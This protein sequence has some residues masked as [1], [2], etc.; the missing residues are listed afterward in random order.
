VAFAP[1]VSVANQAVTATDP[2][3]TC[4]CASQGRRGARTTARR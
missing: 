1:D 4:A 2:A 3:G